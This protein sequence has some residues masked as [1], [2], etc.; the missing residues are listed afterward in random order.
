MLVLATLLFSQLA[1]QTVDT[2]ATKTALLA[3]D[4]ELAH[5][6]ITAPTALLD[7]LEPGAAVLLPAEPIRRGREEART[8]YFKRYPSG[9]MHVEWTPMHAIVS[10]D[11]KLGCTT[12]A[13]ATQSLTL[14]RKPRYGRYVTCWRPGSDGRWRIVAHARNGEAPTVEEPAASTSA[15]H[16]ATSASG[17]LD[18]ALVTDAAFARFALD[19]GP[20]PAFARFAANDAMLLGGRASPPRGPQEIRAVFNGFSAGQRLLWNPMRGAGAASGGLAVTIGLSAT[21]TAAGADEQAPGHYLTV[22]RQEADGSWRFVFDLGSARP[23]DT[24]LDGHLA[25][26]VRL[27]ARLDS[28]HAAGRFPGGT[29]AGSVPDGGVIAVATGTSD[30]VQR[31]VMTTGGLTPR[32]RVSTP[33]GDATRYSGSLPAGYLTELYQ[34]SDRKLTVALRVSSN[35]RSS[36]DETRSALIE[37]A[38]VVANGR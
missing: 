9:T 28:L 37:L 14:D 36:P 16:S 12:G 30:T 32:G 35:S 3:A 23:A 34:F 26:V 31:I 13:T 1:A 24:P 33:M 6:V 25:L 27:Q 21:G 5:T 29:F 7:L 11:G 38:Q 10:S 15:P 18:A 2:T 22:W 19:S 4:R 8:P 20:G 17:D